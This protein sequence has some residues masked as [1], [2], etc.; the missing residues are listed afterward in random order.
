MPASHRPLN[1]LLLGG[2][3]EASVLA[4]RLS[5]DPRFAAVLSLAGRT[6]SPQPSPI[7]QRTGGF[8]GAEG[9]A[10]YLAVQGVDALVVALHPFAARMR[11]NAVEAVIARPTPLVIVDRP[12]WRPQAGDR[13]IFA[14]DM[15][16]AALALGREPRRVLL[17]VGRQD[18]APFKDQPQHLYLARSIDAPSPGDLPAGAQVLLARGPFTQADEERLLS[19]RRI[20]VVVTKNAGARAT[21]AKLAAARA[22]GLR[23]IMVDRPPRPDGAGEAL[24]V[25]G[26]DEAWDWLGGLHHS[27]GSTERGV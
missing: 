24:F 7:P 18:L 25:S 1:I 22:L 17:T 5:D 9:L 11:R 12:P 6:A 21:E 3:S 13:W 26:V 14:P 27:S 4:A 20:D 2:S 23:V 16:A 15:A 8:G 10:D 19:E